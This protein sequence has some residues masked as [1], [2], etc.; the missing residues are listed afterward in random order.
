MS[1][2]QPIELCDLAESCA[3]V[4]GKNKPI[5][6]STFYEGVADGRYPKPVR[7]GPHTVRWPK[8]ELDACVRAMIEARDRAPTPRRRRRR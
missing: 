4:G 1:A 5:S 7:V 6:R 8:H 2:P 3:I